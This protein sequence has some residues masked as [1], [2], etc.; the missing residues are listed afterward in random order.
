MEGKGV[1]DDW[2]TKSLDPSGR[3]DL[4]M[5]SPDSVPDEHMGAR[6]NSIKGKKKHKGMPMYI[7]I[8]ED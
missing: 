8:R 6:S 1:G 3:G 2:L 5:A 7:S 4:S